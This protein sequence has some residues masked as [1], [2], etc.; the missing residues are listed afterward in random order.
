MVSDYGWSF[1]AEVAQAADA[2]SFRKDR[3]GVWHLRPDA[4]YP[5]RLTAA[6][7]GLRM[8]DTYRRCECP[9]LI[10]HCTKV[11]PMPDAKTDEVLKARH[12]WL[13]RELKALAAEKP[14]VRVRTLDTTHLMIFDVPEQVAEDILATAS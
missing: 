3:A 1:P 2:R 10:Y 4:T 5:E 12:R 14:N 9:L 7:A 11:V 6:L 13:Q 8:F